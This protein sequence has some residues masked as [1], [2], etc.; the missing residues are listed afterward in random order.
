[1]KHRKM[2]LIEIVAPSVCLGADTTGNTWP[3]PKDKDYTQ[4]SS[5]NHLK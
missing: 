1:M 4:N 2:C 5:K 3:V